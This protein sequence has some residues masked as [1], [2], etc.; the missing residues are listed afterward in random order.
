MEAHR[1][2]VLRAKDLR[3]AIGGEE[4]IFAFEVR[5]VGRKRNRALMQKAVAG[6]VAVV[7]RRAV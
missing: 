1:I 3:A 5:A 6:C 4:Q 7:E 2:A